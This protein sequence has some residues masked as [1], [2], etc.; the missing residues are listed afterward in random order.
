MVLDS[1]GH[2]AS[3][4]RIDKAKINFATSVTS[5]ELELDEFKDNFTS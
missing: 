2:I 3:V 1:I 4:L 5:T